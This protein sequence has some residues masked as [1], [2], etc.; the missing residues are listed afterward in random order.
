MGAM[1]GMTSNMR[2]SEDVVQA[3]PGNMGAEA[4]GGTT[5]GR[6]E[7][8]E[9]MQVCREELGQGPRGGTTEGGAQGG[10]QEADAAARWSSHRCNSSWTTGA[11][12]ESG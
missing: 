6:N 4:K 1:P 5:G 8:A 12:S 10:A 2:C 9:A 11:A 3:G 7:A